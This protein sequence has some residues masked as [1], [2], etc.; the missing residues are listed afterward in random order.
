MYLL[1]ARE[2]DARAVR[3]VLTALRRSTQRMPPLQ[4]A[5]F[6][7]TAIPPVIEATK[8][9]AA[10]AVSADPGQ[11]RGDN[12]LAE[13]SSDDEGQ[14]SSSS[15]EG[16]HAHGMAAQQPPAGEEDNPSRA[17]YEAAASAAETAV[18]FVAPLLEQACAEGALARDSAAVASAA[19]AADPDIQSGEGERSAY[20]GPGNAAASDLAVAAYTGFAL[21]A[22]EISAET[23][24]SAAT[25]A[26]AAA[27]VSLAE[28]LESDNPA[29]MMKLAEAEEHLVGLVMGSP[30][31]DLPLI[32]LHGYRLSFNDR[33][34][35][36][37]K[38]DGEEGSEVSAPSG[39]R[40]GL[41]GLAELA[42]SGSSPWTL[43]GVSSLAYLVRL[44]P[45][46]TIPTFCGT[47]YLEIV[48]GFAVV[49][50][51]RG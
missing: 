14:D 9:L 43:Q 12:P 15:C 1:S 6:L 49:N 39:G 8:R 41:T 22:L 46:R 10:N 40:G 34:Q 33:V 48:L 11:A 21:S 50:G 24:A 28:A 31:V 16:N 4:R 26:P 25:P 45:F 51:L 32:L 27:V 44:V 13:M 29:F 42:V 47:N 19:A 36:R 7:D 23:S 18:E 37:R 5:K 2:T 20:P 30:V 38:G 35:A 3:A 17:V